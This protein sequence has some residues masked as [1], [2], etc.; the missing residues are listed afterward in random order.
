MGS[1]VDCALLPSRTS[2]PTHHR[3]LNSDV[4]AF[5]GHVSPPCEVREIATF[6]AVYERFMVTVRLLP[7]C[8]GLEARGEVRV[9]D[10]VGKKVVPS[11]DCEAR[12]AEQ[13]AQ[14]IDAMIS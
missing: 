6:G 2:E 3:S 4:G 5:D 1:P 8:L 7:R 14:L 9:I 10:E 13:V 12:I 11:L